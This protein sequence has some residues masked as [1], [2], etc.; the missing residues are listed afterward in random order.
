MS[1]FKTIEI[2][3]PACGV[4]TPFEAV[5]S[6]NA[7]RRP[8]LRQEILANEFQRVQCGSCSAP[9]RLDPSFNYIDLERGQW[10]AALPVVEL[11]NWKLRE[12]AARQTFGLAWG[13]GAGEEAREIGAALRPRL[14]FGWPA[15]R[16]KLLA[17]EHGL[18][19][20]ALEACKAAAMRIKGDIPLAGD[21]DLRLV[22]A[23]SDRLM[24]SWIRSADNA[25][26]EAFAVP[27]SL[28]DSIVADE[29]GEWKGFKLDF[30]DALFVDLNRLLVKQPA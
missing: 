2:K 29:A 9:F 28:H 24:L 20:V 25:M 19:D 17:R 23:G 6:V 7:D 22:E 12:D 5:H 8:D 14:T 21:V 15:L 27:R 4:T 3:C 30:A 1:L 10:I 26:G 16:E 13:E 18:D 11:D